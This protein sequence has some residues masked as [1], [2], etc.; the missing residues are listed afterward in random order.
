MAKGPKSGVTQGYHIPLKARKEYSSLPFLAPYG[1]WPILGISHG[2]FLWARLL[3]EPFLLLLLVSTYLQSSSSVSPF[4]EIILE[5]RQLYFKH[6]CPFQSRL[7]LFLPVYL[8]QNLCGTPVYVKSIHS[9][10]QRLSRD[11]FFPPG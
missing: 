8:S 11:F 4:P 9:F 7:A 2:S 1:Y 5:V 3:S 6:F 10:K